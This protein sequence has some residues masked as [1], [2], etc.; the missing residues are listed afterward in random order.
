MPDEP[1]PHHARGFRTRPPD[2]AEWRQHHYYSRRECHRDD[3][4]GR[5]QHEHHDS[6]WRERS[7]TGNNAATDTNTVN[8]VADLSVTK[9]DGVTTVDAGGTTTFTIVVSNAGPSA[10]GGTA[11]VARSQGHGSRGMAA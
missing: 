10:A 4:L 9:T 1:G 8:P 2:V 7:P 6:G 5:E 3:R 11:V